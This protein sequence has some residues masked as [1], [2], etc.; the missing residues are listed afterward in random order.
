MIELV[1]D[2][3]TIGKEQY[4]IEKRSRI[5]LYQIKSLDKSF[6]E[7]GLTIEDFFDDLES[8]PDNATVYF[9]NLSFDGEFILWYLIENGF[10]YDEENELP[11]TFVNITTELLVHYLI[12]CVLPNGNKVQFR[13]SYRMLPTSLAEL[14]ELVGIKKLSD[15]HDYTSNKFYNHISEVPAEEF[16]YLDADTEILRLA[17]IKLQEFGLTNITASSSAFTSWRKTNWM[18]FKN[19]MNK[20]ADE[21]IN[22]MIDKSYKGG[23]TKLNPIHF[24]KVLTDVYSYDVNSMYPAQMLDTMPIGTPTIFDDLA[25]A[26]SN[27]KYKKFLLAVYVNE[28][29]IIK[30]YHAFIGFNAGFLKT[31]YVYKDRFNDEFIYMWEEEYRLFD[32]YYYHDSYIAKVLGFYQATNVF[33]KYIGHW[34]KLKENSTGVERYMAKLML[35]SLYGKFGQRDFRTTKMLVGKSKEALLYQ[36]IEKDVPYHYRAIASYITAKARCVLVTAIQENADAFVYCDTDSIYLLNQEAKGLPLD[37]HKLG[38]WKFENKCQKF[39]ALKSKCYIKTIE[40]GETIIR[41]AG[42][43]RI[44]ES[45]LTYDNFVPNKKIKGHKKYINRVKGGVIIDTIDFTVKVDN[46]N[47]G[48]I[49]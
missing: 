32:L 7:V 2:F 5:Y 1:A 28:A 45:I 39:K 31:N 19:R 6:N 12:K 44:E 16:K 47:I 42:L 34:S 14:G 33:T 3:E 30:G 11:Y 40:T 4:L 23:I 49:D 22:K 17:V 18:M 13:C 27:P 8:L 25:S 21:E 38:Y 24:N 29:Q 20:P 43:P 46:A 48:L 41:V 35:N 37:D 9:H 26:K 10:V 36:D 15:T